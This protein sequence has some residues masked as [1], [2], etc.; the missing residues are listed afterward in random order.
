MDSN[1]LL[2]SVVYINH[3]IRINFIDVTSSISFTI[4]L[5]EKGRWNDNLTSFKDDLIS[6]GKPSQPFSVAVNQE[7]EPKTM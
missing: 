7:V 5:P 2:P 4:S 1:S 6:A 3:I